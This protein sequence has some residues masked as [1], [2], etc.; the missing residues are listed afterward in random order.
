[1][2]RYFIFWVAVVLSVG[3]LTAQI[4][5]IEKGNNDKRNSI[6]K[7][8]N[9]VNKP[10][11]E[12]GISEGNFIFQDDKIIVQDG[13]SFIQEEKT[14]KRD[15]ALN[16]PERKS[17]EMLNAAK[18]P[19]KKSP[20]V[21]SVR[22]TDRDDVTITL[23]V[24]GSPIM[25]SWGVDAG[26]HMLLDSSGELYEYFM[27][28]ADW[29]WNT[30]IYDMSDYS[31]PEN[32]DPDPDEPIW[33]LDDEASIDIPAGVYDFVVFFIIPEYYM[34]ASSTLAVNGVYYWSNV[35]SYQ[36]FAG[37]DYTFTVEFYEEWWQEIIN[38][39]VPIDITL[40]DLILPPS[41]VGLTNEEDITIVIKNIGTETITDYVEISYTVNDGI[42]VK[43]NYYINSLE[44]DEEIT[45]IFETKA[46]FSLVGTYN[47]DVEVYYSKDMWPYYQ[48]KTGKTRHIPINEL[49]WVG[50]I[51]TQLEFQEQWTVINADGDNRR[52]QWSQ[53]MNPFGVRGSTQVNVPNNPWGH[54]AE[55]YII[56]EPVNLPEPGLYN[57]SFYTYA[58]GNEKFKVLYGMSPDYTEMEVLESYDLIGWLSRWE[59]RIIEFEIETPGPYY[60][61]FL[62][63][64][65]NLGG[66]AM[67]ME[68][69]TVM[70]QEGEFKA[71][72]DLSFYRIIAPTPSCEME[73]ATIGVEI[74]N[75]GASVVEEF[76]VTYQVDDGEI[77]SQTFTETIGMLRRITVYFTQKADFSEVKDYNIHFT[78]STEDE[79][80]LDDNETTVVVRH[81]EPI[82]DVPFVHSFFD[83]FDRLNWNQNDNWYYNTHYQALVPLWHSRTMLSN[84]ISL[85]PGVYHFVYLITAGGSSATDD[86]Y[87]TYGKSGTNPDDWEPVNE[88]YD[89]STGPNDVDIVEERMIVVIT[90][91][92]EYQI[93]F[94]AL[95][96]DQLPNPLWGCRT[97]IFGVELRYAPEHDFTINSV[98]SQGISRLMP[99]YQLINERT[100]NAEIRNLG[101]TANENGNLK[102]MLNDIEIES[103]PFAF[104]EIG[105]KLNI[106]ITHNFESVPAGDMLFNFKASLE[107]GF[108][109]EKSLLTIAT[110]ST[111]ALDFK[112]TGFYSALS[113]TAPGSFGMI[114]EL[115]KSDILTSI[116]LGLIDVTSYGGFDGNIGLAVYK[117]DENM[118][119]YDMFFYVEH[120]R[121]NGNSE[122]SITFAVP[123]TELEPG[124]YYFEVRQLG[125]PPIRIAADG[126]SEGFCF[127][128]INNNA[129]P[130]TKHKDAGY[131]H[132]RPNFG[133]HIYSVTA[134]S[135]NPDFGSVTG[136]GDFSYGTIATLTAIPNTG[137]HFVNWTE[138]DEVVAEAGASYPIIVTEPRDLVANFAINTYTIAVSI[139]PEVGGSVEGGGEYTHGE[140]VTLTATATEG[141]K[142]VIW[143]EDGEEVTDT[144]VYTFIAEADRDLVASFTWDGNITRVIADDIVLYPNPFTNEINISNPAAVKSVTITNVAGQEIK[145]TVFNGKSISTEKFASGIYFVAVE[146]VTGD[147]MVYKMVKK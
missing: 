134:N 9:L 31:I 51:D 114:F 87:V 132:I 28:N 24:I 104:T 73:E 29:G 58:F 37:Y 74:Y 71:N 35:S 50:R 99:S 139:Y 79:E 96:M 57:V 33:V 101:N 47:V 126:S 85:E 67:G 109:Y 17:P 5:V 30:E 66:G 84:C 1:M 75:R 146:S 105:H 52:W 123:E 18:L 36:F 15:K 68:L 3:Y 142:F 122:K 20:P 45:V 137:Y 136:S 89:Y 106:E 97:A 94:V 13:T 119:P 116:S 103:E 46:D 61:A 107:E 108:E 8:S 92:D 60:F 98:S 113:L 63:C 49:P 125:I 127:Y 133:K 80:N 64:T 21:V 112:D 130:P 81:L 2:K 138:N 7:E 32:A 42:P 27:Y 38:L 120:P 147:K 76:T 93:A 117:I 54:V 19:G 40:T 44:P 53:N 95:N 41:A 110:D 141:Y 70:V 14:L 111:L 55:D 6:I 83:P 135:A 121:T 4:P 22:K 128:S 23:K 102:L 16:L 124:K 86:L 82:K 145:Q 59:V 88:H 69:S 12:Q 25:E 10:V 78:V 144:E 131:L 34:M 62:Y 48:T 72:P 11:I 65:P 100:F 43:E 90:E 118:L 143:T 115:S 77:V 39:D 140:S 56:S 26:F 91:E 129:T